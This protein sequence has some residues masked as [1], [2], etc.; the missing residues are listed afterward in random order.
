MLSIRH[1]NIVQHCRR[2]CKKVNTALRCARLARLF[3]QLLS[4]FALLC[5]TRKPSSTVSYGISNEALS[6]ATSPTFRWLQKVVRG[7]FSIQKNETLYY[8]Y[9]MM[10]Y[11]VA[12]SEVS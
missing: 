10:S 2:D 1:I 9:V 6:K 3:A 4:L 8:V 12:P 11:D 5:V 7:M